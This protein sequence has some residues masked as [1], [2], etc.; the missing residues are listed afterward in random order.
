[1]FRLFFFAL[2][3]H[4]LE[5][6]TKQ[7]THREIAMPKPQ[8][9]TPPWSAESRLLFQKLFGTV[10]NESE[11]KNNY[12]TKHPLGKVPGVK[13]ATSGTFAYSRIVTYTCGCK[14]HYVNVHDVINA[15]DYCH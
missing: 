7:M 4:C 12:C 1:M 14:I 6:K 5:K 3:P 11:D 15:V 10:P 9:T 13:R 2:H 8:Q